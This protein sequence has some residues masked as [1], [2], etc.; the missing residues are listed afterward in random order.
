M[1]PDLF[2]GI[3][4]VQDQQPGQM[5]NILHHLAAVVVSAQDLAGML[6]ITCEWF[7]R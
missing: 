7:A 4:T 5:P 6:P 3:Q 1:R 2:M